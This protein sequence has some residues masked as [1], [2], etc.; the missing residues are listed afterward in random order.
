VRRAS[1]LK[2]FGSDFTQQAVEV[3]AS[4]DHGATWSY[5]SSCASE[6]GLANSIG[7]GI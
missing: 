3:F 1:R 4:T 5:R 6:S 2:L 7:H